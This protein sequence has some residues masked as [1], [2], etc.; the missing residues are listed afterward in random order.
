MGERGWEMTQ[1]Y[2]RFH[3]HQYT[4]MKNFTKHPVLRHEA[5]MQR[6]LNEGVDEDMVTRCLCCARDRY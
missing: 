5:R 4:H 6:F 3:V 2:L 1:I